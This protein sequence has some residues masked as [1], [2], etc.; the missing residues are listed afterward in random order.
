MPV[1]ERRKGVPP[2]SEGNMPRKDVLQFE[3]RTGRITIDYGRCE[4]VVRNTASPSCGFACVKADRWYG[5]NVLKIEN[6]RPVLAN[7]D[8][9]EVKR[10]CNECLACEYDCAREGRECIRIELPFPG[11]EEYRRK[12]SGGRGHSRR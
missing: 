2:A 1:P 9:E 3:T 7:A 12:E 4:P 11:L 6:N 5:R 8:P 10:G